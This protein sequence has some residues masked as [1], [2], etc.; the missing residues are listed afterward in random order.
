MVKFILVFVDVLENNNFSIL[1][2]LRF[3]LFDFSWVVNCKIFFNFLEF[4]F[5]RF[6]KFCFFNLF[7]IYY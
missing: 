5:V 4:K 6:N 2:Y 7:I 3:I 1:L